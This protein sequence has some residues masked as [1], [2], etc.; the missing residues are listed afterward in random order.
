MVLW[1]NLGLVALLAAVLFVTGRSEADRPS[2]GRGHVPPADAGAPDEAEAHQAE[3]ETSQGFVWPAG[4]DPFAAKL[5]EGRYV[6]V[7]GDGTKVYYGFNPKM[8]R[9]AEEI[10][11][12]YPIPHGAVVAM[13]PHT[14]LIT[15]WAG[16]SSTG[17]DPKSLPL[18]AT[19]PAASTF[20]IVTTSALLQTGVV[21]ERQK[22]CYHGGL[23]RLAKGN[24]IDDPKRDRAC[25]PFR[26]ALAHS[27]NAVFAKLAYKHLAEDTL[28]EYAERFG[29]NQ[30]LDFPL[31]LQVSKAEVPKGDRL[32]FARM[33]AGFWHV[34]Q[35]PV[36]GLMVASTIANAGVRVEPH[37]VQE[38]V[39]ADGRV[40]YRA[41]PKV[42]A[43]AV[44]EDIA[45]RVAKLMVRTTKV[46]TARRR[47]GRRGWRHRKV[48]VAGKTGSLTRRS[49]P[50]IH[51]TW[52]VGFAPADA[53]EMAVSA[54]VGNAPLWHIKATYLA[55]EVLDAYF[56][57]KPG[58]ASGR[59]RRR[60]ARAR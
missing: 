58:R 11:A 20:K 31:P 52:F 42:L 39:A 53:P 41:E 18:D 17:L 12:R 23:R 35:S 33:A 16:R 59:G 13:D 22:I 14:G 44:R 27:T 60:G 21:T 47:F 28:L 6:Q 30:P 37:L 43:K 15:V 49:D 40:L 45:R 57:S 55:R 4:I 10:L 5:V 32:E 54:V 48:A 51:F 56:R 24:I 25:I 3:S 9:R 50:P 29:F 38:I 1:I 36:Q 8:Q 34:L 2:P 7:L 26:D 19:P 46:G